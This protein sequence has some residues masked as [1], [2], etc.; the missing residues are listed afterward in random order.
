MLSRDEIR[1]VPCPSCAAPAGQ[2]CLNERGVMRSSNH[3]ERMVLAE[4]ARSQPQRDLPQWHPEPRPC[5][6]PDLR[7]GSG[8]IVICDH[9]RK[10]GLAALARI[11][12]ERASR[13]GR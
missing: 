12:A 5:G 2:A 13:H 7:D 1:S 3:A 6:C 8:A 4:R 10:T 11:R 9:E